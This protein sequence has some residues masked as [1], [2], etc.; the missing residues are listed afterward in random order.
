MLIAVDQ[1]TTNTKALLIDR[2]GNTVYKTVV[3]T[4]IRFAEN[5]KISQDLECL[6]QSTLEVL[7]R[8][9]AWAQG[10][11]SVID[12]LCLANQRETAAAWDRETGAPRAAAISWQCRRSSSICER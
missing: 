9:N 6:W 8:C 10:N 12:G 1:G 11:H 3:P 5:G 2:E 7:Q 4:P